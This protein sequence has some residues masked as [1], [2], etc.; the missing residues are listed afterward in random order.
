MRSRRTSNQYDSIQNVRVKESK[1]S[2]LKTKSKKRQTSRS[3]KRVSRRRKPVKSPRKSKRVKKKSKRRMT[4]QRRISRRRSR[5]HPTDTTPSES[6]PI[7]S[8]DEYIHALITGSNNG[9]VQVLL[10]LSPNVMDIITTDSG[11]E[12]RV[13]WV[14][15]GACNSTNLHMLA[16][17]FQQT[18]LDNHLMFYDPRTEYNIER[19]IHGPDP[20]GSMLYFIRSTYSM[21]RRDP[22]RKKKFDNMITCL[23]LDNDKILSLSDRLRIPRNPDE[24][25]NQSLERYYGH[26]I[27]PELSTELSTTIYN[28]QEHI[29]ST[30]VKIRQNLNIIFKKGGKYTKEELYSEVVGPLQVLWGYFMEILIVAQMHSPD[31]LI[32]QMVILTGVNHFDSIMQ[33]P[34]IEGK[35]LRYMSRRAIGMIDLES[36]FLKTDRQSKILDGLAKREI[37]AKVY[38]GEAMFDE[39]IEYRSAPTMIPQPPHYTEIVAHGGAAPRIRGLENTAMPDL[40]MSLHEAEDT[41]LIPLRNTLI[42]NGVQRF[43]QIE[44]RTRVGFRLITVLGELHSIVTPHGFTEDEVFPVSH[45]FNVKS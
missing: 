38:E 9:E 37:N 31:D 30:K 28:A 39:V 2:R 11:Q 8:V 26:L 10:E 16:S 22:D 6:L 13:N 36:T 12:R 14:R 42:L 35:V 33:L 7:I 5:S 23:G 45:G 27:E 34:L 15:F 21:N 29:N 32:N 20:A 43:A 40:V 19:N 41:G 18:S 17:M 1:K 44:I 25:L 3:P 24:N 4:T